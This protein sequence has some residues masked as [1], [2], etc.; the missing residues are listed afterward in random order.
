MAGYPPRELERVGLLRAKCRSGSWGFGV[1]SWYL[2]TEAQDEIKGS[3]SW[4]ACG[5]H[6]IRTNG[7]KIRLHL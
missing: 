2:G 5:G 7:S 4:A 3:G 6:L 1:C